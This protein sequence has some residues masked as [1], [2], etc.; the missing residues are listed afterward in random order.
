MK[1]S[2]IAI[3]IIASALYWRTLQQDS[4]ANIER[5]RTI[6]AVRTENVLNSIFHKTDVLAAVVKL[7]NGK[8]DDYVFDSIAKLDQCWF[9]HRVEWSV[10]LQLGHVPNGLNQ[11]FGCQTGPDSY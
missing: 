5:M 11:Q 3:S 9:R 7:R 2:S 4:A 1:I 10:R 8:M 6:Y